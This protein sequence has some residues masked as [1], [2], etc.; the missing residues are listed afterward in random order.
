LTTAAQPNAASQARQL[1]QIAQ[2]LVHGGKPALQVFDQ[3]VDIF[4]ANVQP[5]YRIQCPICR[6]VAILGI[7]DSDQAFIAAPGRAQTKHLQR[8][9]E[10]LDVRGVG[11]ARAGLGVTPRS[12]EM[13]GP[14][15]RVLGENDGLPRLP[16]VTSL[17]STR[18]KKN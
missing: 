15:M 1:L 6:A 3:R 2:A 16:D 7:G 18:T 9:N 12:M 4:Q 10:P 11:L 8:I 17:Q 13:L 14:D 5:Q